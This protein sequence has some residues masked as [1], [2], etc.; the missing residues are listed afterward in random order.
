MQ[1]IFFYIPIKSILRSIFMRYYISYN[2]NKA[3]NRLKISDCHF[4]DMSHCDVYKIKD[5]L[6]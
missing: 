4:T 2:T 3:I 5:V 6:Q 1:L